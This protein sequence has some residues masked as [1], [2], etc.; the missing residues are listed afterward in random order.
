MGRIWK[1]ILVGLL[2]FGLVF[3]VALTFFSR[4][5]GGYNGNG[6]SYPGWMMGGWGNGPMMGSW[7]Y[8]PMM[9]GFGIFGWV[10]MLL[11]F[12]LLAGVIALIVFGVA[13]LV[14]HPVATTVMPAQAQ[15]QACPSCGKPVQADWKNCP[16]CGQNL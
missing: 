5:I 2:V 13:A 16:Y 3:V 9:G 15:V 10:M 4:G 6:V 14:R 11:G 8:G 1:Y 12:L 7:S